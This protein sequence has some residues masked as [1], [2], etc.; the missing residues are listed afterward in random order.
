[1]EGVAVLPHQKWRRGAD[2][3]V[4]PHPDLVVGQIVGH[5]MLQKWLPCASGKYCRAF[6]SYA[7]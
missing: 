4:N 1:M 6:E 7:L 3:V 5:A 2:P